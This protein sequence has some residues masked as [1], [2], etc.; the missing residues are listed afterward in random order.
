MENKF[1]YIDNVASAADSDVVK[2]RT[3]PLKA[4]V[5]LIVGAGVL[6]Y[7]AAHLGG[8]VSEVLS[9]A[10][11][12][13]GLIIVI[14]G[15]GSFF[16]KRVKYIYKPTGKALKKC[17]V[18]VSPNYSSKL[19]QMVEDGK[20]EELKTLPRVPQSNLSIEALCGENGQYAMLQ[21]LEFVPYNDVPTTPVKVVQGE[22]A[23]F[24]SDFLK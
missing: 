6:Y 24:V 17:K 22:Q 13:A 12:I 16:S 1:D 4:I 10:L 8:S 11:I 2:K 5:L 15:I 3:S 19:Y 14:W 20:F 18:Y 9:S 23:K 7:G 21:V